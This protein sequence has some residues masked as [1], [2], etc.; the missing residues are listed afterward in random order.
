MPENYEPQK[1]HRRSIRLKDYDYIQP[2]AYF[3]TI[4]AWHRQAIFGPVQAGEMVLNHY[5]QI[6]LDAWQ[7]LPGHYPNVMLQY[8]CVM[9][10]HVHGIIQ[11]IEIDPCRG[12]SVT[13]VTSE[14]DQVMNKFSQEP[15]GGKTRPYDLPHGLPEI[16]RAF[17][18]FSARQINY[19][20]QTPGTPVWQ[21]NYYERVVRNDDELR[22]MAEYILN[23]PSGW[24]TDNENPRMEL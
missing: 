19:L 5:G 24:D 17:K 2:G 23:N 12:G 14:A 4:V 18:S 3:V 9:P 7:G 16:V 8:F 10:N 13:K 22:Q 20:R 1:H 11:L 6:V 21:R 15:I